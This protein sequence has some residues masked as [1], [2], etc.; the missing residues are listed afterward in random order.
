[1]KRVL[2]LSSILLM[3]LAAACTA[4][5]PQ[6]GGR[7]NGESLR[8]AWRY[9]IGEPI[10]LTPLPV[11]KILVTA[12]RESGVVGLALQ[13]GELVWRYQPDGGIWE[14]ALGTDGKYVFVGVPGGRL[15]ALDARSGKPKWEKTLGIEV[16]APLRVYQGNLYVPTTYVGPGLAGRA[17]GQAKLFALDP[18]DGTILWN[19]ESE[20]YILQ[21]PYRVGDMVYTGGSYKDEGQEIEEGGPL[22]IYALSAANGVLKWVYQSV[23]GYVKALYATNDAVAYIAYQ[24]YASG[25][26][27]SSGELIWR[28]DTGN[29]VPAL[30]GVGNTVY[31][32]SANTIFKAVD[33]RT[34]EPYWEYNIG[35]GSF[36]Y[37]LGI[38]SRVGAE[39]YF[40]TQQGDIIALNVSDGSELWK[41]P[42]GITA[43][44]GL[45][46]AGS[47]LFIGDQDGVV[48]A[49][50]SD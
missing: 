33:I 23:D 21:T 6:P 48:Y 9:E 11:G 40:L 44:E 30:T 27:A 34:G 20:S 28:K 49:Y 46:V 45:A 15:V 37:M 35:G 36:N 39:L 47:W 43:R 26:D 16:Q 50:R 29:W 32:G 7:L 18:R 42:T 19:F 10:N 41:F 22:K 12:G 3:V 38:P 5:Q 8:L 2:P 25:L 1:M 13:S 24:D 14:R 31:Y 17:L 4:L